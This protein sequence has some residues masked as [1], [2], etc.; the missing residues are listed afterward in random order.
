M[1]RMTE[2]GKDEEPPQRMQHTHIHTTH[3][4]HNKAQ[5]HKR[6]P[7]PTHQHTRIKHTHTHT[8]TNTHTHIQYTHTTHRHATTTTKVFAELTEVFAEPTR[9]HCLHST[10]TTT[11][12][13]KVGHLVLT[14]RPH[15]THTQ[16]Q[17][18]THLP[19]STQW[20]TISHRCRVA[21]A[22]L[23]CAPTGSA[24]VLNRNF[25]QNIQRLL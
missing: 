6:T 8:H 3:I 5:P 1:T 20:S 9:L 18:G 16:T 21:R 14:K 24:D 23:R 13:K 22:K 4:Q 10:T 15:H 12:I 17:G 7:T 25:L 11:A 19:A 2:K